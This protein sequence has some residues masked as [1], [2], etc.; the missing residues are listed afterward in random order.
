MNNKAL[1]PLRKAIRYSFM[2]ATTKFRW[3]AKSAAPIK[4]VDTKTWTSVFLLS[5]TVQVLHVIFLVVTIIRMALSN[6]KLVNESKI[7]VE[8]M[9][10]GYSVP[11]FSMQLF[12]IWGSQTMADF[13]NTLIVTHNI[14]NG[15]SER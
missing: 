11:I 3:D 4:V 12:L 9:A 6:N 15:R 14:I 5:F 13:L 2:W 7:F 10:V 1:G 8:F